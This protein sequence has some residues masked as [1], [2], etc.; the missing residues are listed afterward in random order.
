MNRTP[1]S[2]PLVDTAIAVV[3]DAI[4]AGLGRTRVDGVIEVVALTRQG[5][6]VAFAGTAAADVAARDG[7]T[8]AVAVLVRVDVADL[9]A[10]AILVD[11]VARDLGSAGVHVR[12]GVVAVLLV[13]PPADGPRA[14]HGGHVGIPLRIAIGVLV[15]GR[16]GGRVHVAV[17]VVHAAIAVVVDVV[18]D[19]VGVQVD[20]GVRVVTVVPVVGVALGRRLAGVGRVV[21][22]AIAVTV[23]VREELVRIERVV[24]H[25]VVAVVVDFV[26]DLH[27]VGMHR[28]I[29]VVTVVAVLHV[30]LGRRTSQLPVLRR[31]VVVAITIEEE[32]RRRRTDVAIVVV[33]VVVVV[34][35]AIR[36]LL[37]AQ[38]SAI[39]IAV[40]VAVAVVV[41]PRVETTVAGVRRVPATVAGVHNLEPG[42][43][44]GTLI[45]DGAVGV[46]TPVRARQLTVHV[47]GMDVG[48]AVVAV[49]TNFAL[50][51]SAVHGDLQ[52]IIE[53][54][55]IETIGPLEAA[56]QGQNEQ[57][58]YLT[59]SQAC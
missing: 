15:V 56:R 5:G 22:V 36:L 34:G 35:V 53:V 45:D 10:V 8:V 17:L 37:Q 24:V 16:T 3:V 50:R 19:L 32:D 47:P 44:H 51:I 18:A 2:A 58:H 43:F 42:V 14:R 54:T 13:A 7:R 23:R 39:R 12:V 31:S 30:V 1:I 25:Q 29:L 52:I 20:L 6:V 46:L 48:V 27:G 33:T 41:P 21:D 59:S 11:L 57:E 49:R 38:R 9:G 26:A 40:A 28:V 55:D 4:V